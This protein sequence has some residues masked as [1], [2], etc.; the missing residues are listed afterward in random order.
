MVWSGDG[1]LNWRC[2]L[3][4]SLPTPPPSSARDADSAVVQHVRP[5]DPRA[6]AQRAAATRL[7]G[8][9]P[10]PHRRQEEAGLPDGHGRGAS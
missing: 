2:F 8:D 6:L 1:A 4:H 10:E 5:G 3:I 9:D 7:V